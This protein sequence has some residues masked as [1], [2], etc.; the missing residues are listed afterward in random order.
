M[1][2]LL[3]IVF[4]LLTATAVGQ[5]TETWLKGSITYRTAQHSYVQFPNT[6]G[7]QLGDTLYIEENS[8]KKPIFVV[9]QLSSQSC[10][11]LPI[12][13]QPVDDTAILYARML[14][15][16]R[17]PPFE[18]AKHLETAQPVTTEAIERSLNVSEKQRRP[19]IDGKIAL[20]SYSQLSSFGSNQRLRYNLSLNAHNIDSSAFSA[21]TNLSFSHQIAAWNGLA[22]ALKVYSLAVSYQATTHLIVSAGRKIN[23]DM[24][25]IG[26]VD[27]LQVEYRQKALSYGFL[28]GSRPDYFDYSFNPKLLQVGAFI[29]HT[30]Q[31]PTGNYQTT[32]AVFNQTNAFRTDRRFAYVQHSNALLKKLTAFASAEIDFY[33]LKNGLPSTTFQWTSTYLSLR[34]K[35]WEKF[36]MNLSYDARKNSYYYETFKNQ[37]DSIIDRETRQGLR[38]GFTYHP[39]NRWMW[40]GNAGY[41]LKSSGTS[42]SL[43]ANT[44]LTLAE[45]PFIDASATLDATFLQ[46]AYLN[47]TVYGLQLS[48]DL[49]KEKVYAELGY[50]AVNYHYTN[51]QSTLL[52]HITEASFSWRLAK[53][54]MAS[55][56]AEGSF[57][58]YD[59]SARL[60]INLTKRF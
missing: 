49:F 7:I 60:Y 22:D 50:R 4:V 57:D 45:I 33:T 18:T 5:T 14:T 54:W 20:T 42:P 17:N 40:G 13:Q 26:A 37:L 53:K 46:T 3:L 15:V 9:Q 2:H 6:K 28:L 23:P 19:T 10:L 24:A 34:Y 11:C 16:H 1:K 12:N 21:E 35:P 39:F 27:G 41:R 30:V 51:T 56:N 38:L 31:T 52:Q 47:G 29:G 36:S 32:L 8:L 59:T 58:A 48:K 43:N 44:Y 25:N 55:F